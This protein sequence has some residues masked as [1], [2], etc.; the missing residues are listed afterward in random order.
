MFQIVILNRCQSFTEQKVGKHGILNILC[1][2]PNYTFS[3][4]YAKNP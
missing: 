4:G 3:R 2:D 1:D